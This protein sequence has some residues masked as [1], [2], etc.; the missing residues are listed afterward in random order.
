M[1]T[2]RFSSSGGGSAHPTPW[3]QTRPCGQT[4][5]Y[6]N[7]TLPQTSF[8]AVNN[9]SSH[10]FPEHRFESISVLE[11]SVP[12]RVVENVL[13]VVLNEFHIRVI[14]SLCGIAKRHH[15]LHGDVAILPL[16]PKVQMRHPE[17]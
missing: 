17:C 7:I 6:E 11:P 2:T 12:E 3:M 13:R 10:N 9:L 16:S 15:F 1:R 14:N 4:N 5:T 8:A